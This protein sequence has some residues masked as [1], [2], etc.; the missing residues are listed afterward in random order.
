[1]KSMI[2]VLPALA[3]LLLLAAPAL[4]QA[5]SPVAGHWEGSLQIQDRELNIQ[6]DLAP[7]AKGIWV[8]AMSIPQQNMTAFPL[9]DIAVKENAASFALK[10]L[11]GDPAFK[12]TVSA[13]GKSLSGVFT[14]G[15]ASIPFKA[16]R[17]GDAK[18][19]PPAKST[20]VSKAIE[21]TWEGAIT[22]NSTTLRL[23]LNLANQPDGATGKLI[24]VDQGGAQI[25]IA[26]V[27]QEGSKLKLELP[28]VAGAFTGEVNKDS[29]EIAGNFSQGGGE[30]ALVFRRPEKKEK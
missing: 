21:G 1:M 2:R 3:G 28:A 22:V 23:V 20:P 27:T 5:A 6:I 9:S 30:R 24:S 29:T 25:P 13:D 18:V 12:G 14:Q 15:G 17:T 7:D 11:P 16:S 8:G 26:T 19:Q 4:P 10:G